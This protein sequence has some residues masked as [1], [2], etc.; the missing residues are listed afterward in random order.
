ML[1]CTRRH[2]ETARSRAGPAWNRSSA[3]AEVEA[4]A[5]RVRPSPRRS[6]RPRFASRLAR[7][8]GSGRSPRAGRRHSRGDRHPKQGPA[9]VADPS[10]V[11]RDRHPPAGGRGCLAGC[12]S[13]PPV[14]RGQGSPLSPAPPRQREATLGGPRVDLRIRARPVTR[15]AQGLILGGPGHARRELHRGYGGGGARRANRVP[16]R[17][18][19]GKRTRQLDSVMIASGGR[20]ASDLLRAPANACPRSPTPMPQDLYRETAVRDDGPRVGRL[21]TSP[22]DTGS[23]RHRPRRS[24]RQSSRSRAGWLEG[25]FDSSTDSVMQSLN[26]CG[27]FSAMMRCLRRRRA[28]ERVSACRR[29]RHAIPSRRVRCA[30]SSLDPVLFVYSTAAG[31]RLRR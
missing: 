21:L 5:R 7:S 17:V 9:A 24:G 1:A 18:A 15:L 2:T 28:V 25:H 11:R 6:S 23:G 3:A 13:P 19:L 22:P 26:C 14:T 4:G 31:T 27:V 20:P 8:P 30:P 16:G 12:A 29:V 10:A